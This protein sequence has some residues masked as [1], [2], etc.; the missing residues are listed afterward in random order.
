MNKI[1]L[2]N[3]GKK[4]KEIILGLVM[5]ISILN[6]FGSH[7]IHKTLKKCNIFNILKIMQNV[8]EYFLIWVNES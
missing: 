6:M 5:H 3:I 7:L 4:G 1:I 8:N 2:L